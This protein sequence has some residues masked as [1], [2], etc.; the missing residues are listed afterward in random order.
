[1][2]TV[3]RNSLLKTV[4]ALGSSFLMW[5]ACERNRKR[6]SSLSTRRILIVSR[7][8]F[9]DPPGFVR[10]LGPACNSSLDR[11]SSYGSFHY[12]CISIEVHDLP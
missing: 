4:S 7:R 3:V 5:A 6:S 1:M 2:L 10:R 12:L 8:V 11:S 9:R